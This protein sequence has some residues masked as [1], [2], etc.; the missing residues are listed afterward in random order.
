MAIHNM[1][2][3]V[4]SVTTSGSGLSSA[5]VDQCARREGV[6]GVNPDENAKM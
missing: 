3:D 4:E 6:G 2:M 5:V 1:G